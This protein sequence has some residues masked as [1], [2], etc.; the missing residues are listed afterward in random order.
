MFQDY[1]KRSRIFIVSILSTAV[2]V[3]AKYLLNMY[4]LEPIGFSALYSTLIAGGFFVIGFIMSATIAD[5]KESEK[6]PSEFCAVV[7]NIYED[8]LGISHNYPDFD[9]DKFRLCLIDILKSTKK[10]L[11]EAQRVARHDV[12][13]ISEYFTKMEDAGVPPNFITKLK[14]EQG[15][16]I[17]ML[18]RAYYIQ[19]IK[20][21]P[22]ASVLAKSIVVSLIGLLLLTD[23]DPPSSSIWLTG[24]ISY[25][26]IY[27]LM[28]I[29]VIGTP[30]H[31]RGA[32]RDDVS[33]FLFDRA[34][35][36]MEREAGIEESTTK[37]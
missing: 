31:A 9:I 18:F 2:I 20:F 21:I 26:F 3:V 8:S 33:L 19:T 25:L 14:Q 5:Y 13:M 29:S 24:V 27:M 15:N 35:E 12:H 30:F 23:I 11:V 4:Q 1:R 6:F 17:R 34:I 28:L 37:P 36:H 10:D 7:E 32:T 16:L 22:S